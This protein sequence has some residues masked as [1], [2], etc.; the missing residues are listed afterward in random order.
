MKVIEL[1]QTHASLDEVIDQAQDELAVLRKAN[2]SVFALSHVDEFAVE[3]ELLKDNPE[4][5]ALLRQ[6]SEEP[7]TISLEDFRQE[8]AS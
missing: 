7:A 4:F 6:L 3:V 1:S 5:L 8:L 2:G